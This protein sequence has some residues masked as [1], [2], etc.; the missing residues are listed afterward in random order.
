[1]YEQ[2]A[3]AARAKPGL[4]LLELLL[5]NQALA[6][7]AALLGSNYWTSPQVGV[8]ITLNDAVVTSIRS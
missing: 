1:M 3:R 4:G 2:L 5:G 7:S 6:V 8:P